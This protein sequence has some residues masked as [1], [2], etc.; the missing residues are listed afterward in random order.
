MRRIELCTDLR[1]GWTRCHDGLGRCCLGLSWVITVLASSHSL[2][3]HFPRLLHI[4]GKLRK[5][6]I[7]AAPFSIE[8]IIWSPSIWTA[9]HQFVGFFVWLACRGVGAVIQDAVLFSRRN[10]PGPFSFMREGKKRR[11]HS[12]VGKRLQVEYYERQSMYYR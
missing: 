3:N 7:L 8:T 5:W 10:V 12:R 6:C 4:Y 9:R 1:T 11:R 2:S